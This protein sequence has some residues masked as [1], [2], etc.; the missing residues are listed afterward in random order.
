M[1]AKRYSATQSSYIHT[2]PPR[3]LPNMSLLLQGIAASTIR[4]GAGFHWL[5]QFVGQALPVY[6]GEVSIHWCLDAPKLRSFWTWLRL[7]SCRCLFHSM[8]NCGIAPS[9]VCQS[10][11]KA[12]LVLW[13]L[14][15]N[16][17]WPWEGWTHGI[18][19]EDWRYPLMARNLGL[20]ATLF[21]R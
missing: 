11:L 17:Q 6:L 18:C 15:Y 19:T 7:F 1:E 8:R 20:K 5:C 16:L 12:L 4:T 14:R 9:F 21:C 3:S 13:F 2:S 10:G